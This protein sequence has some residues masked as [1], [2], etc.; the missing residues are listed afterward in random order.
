M[1]GLVRHNLANAIVGEYAEF[2][3]TYTQ[4]AERA[5]AA[6]DK[7]VANSCREIAAEEAKHHP[8]FRAAV[9]KSLKPD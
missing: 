1:Y 4:T 8:D 3:Q 6:G 2:S 5:E 7:D 9:S